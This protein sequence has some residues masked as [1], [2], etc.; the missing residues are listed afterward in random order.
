MTRIASCPESP[1]SATPHWNQV[2]PSGSELHSAKRRAVLRE[3]AQAFNRQGYHATTLESVA[4]RLGITKAAIYHYFPNKTALLKACF[5][6]VMEAA[7][8]NLAHA[9]A[10]GRNGREKLR[11]VFAGY[12]AHILDEV[13]VAVVV[14][15]DGAL[16][17]EDRR[18]AYAKR[19]RF[20][21]A[22]RELVQEGIEDG[23]V[24]PCDP[25]LVIMALLGAVN[26]VPRWYRRDGEWSAEQLA[27]LMSELLDRSISTQPSRSLTRGVKNART[28]ADGSR[29]LAGKRAAP[30]SR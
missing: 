22:L 29:R 5:D 17:A 16:T 1:L 9:K 30:R 25:K 24:V 2:V 8:T 6:E 20:E 18:S 7:F 4:K 26:W 12:L 14:L 11:G 13:T 21:H 27:T 3:A 10:N 28:G 19:D 23:S 15:D